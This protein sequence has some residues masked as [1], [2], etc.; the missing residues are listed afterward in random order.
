[1]PLPSFADASLFASPYS[2]SL[3]LAHVAHLFCW[4]AHRFS[5]LP[6]ALFR[7]E[8]RGIHLNHL[9][10]DAD[11]KQ[12]K[13]KRKNRVKIRVTLQR[14]SYPPP[15]SEP[16]EGTYPMARLKNSNSKENVC[17]QIL[18]SCTEVKVNPYHELRSGQE[19]FF[20]THWK[21]SSFPETIHSQVTFMPAYVCSFLHQRQLKLDLIWEKITNICHETRVTIESALEKIKKKKIFTKR[22]ITIAPISFGSENNK[23]IPRNV[24]NNKMNPDSVVARVLR[25]DK[26]TRLAFFPNAFNKNAGKIR[27][28]Y[29]FASSC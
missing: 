9:G 19:F 12:E 2:A 24:M 7:L 4:I 13:Q 10:G 18:L 29:R 14:S 26:T 1:M 22:I 3:F 25:V 20:V 17:P 15:I 11:G 21:Y 8:I 23:R 6:S 5:S 27:N 16:M 28:R